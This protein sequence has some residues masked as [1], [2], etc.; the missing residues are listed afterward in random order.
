MVAH[1]SV[2]AM[3]E[4][5]LDNRQVAPS[6]CPVQCSPVCVCVCVCVC[7][8][9][10]VCVCVCV[11]VHLFVFVCVHI[12]VYVYACFVII[13]GWVCKDACHAC[14]YSSVHA[15]EVEQTTLKPCK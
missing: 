15:E 14:I 11:C 5:I 2:S 9:V 13:R 10:C 3:L 12:L 7:V 8:R 1:T 4:E 6:T